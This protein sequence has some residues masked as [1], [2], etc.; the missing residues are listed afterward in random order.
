MSSGSYSST[1]IQSD[2]IAAAGK[3]GYPQFDNMQNLDAINGV[4]R[5]LRFISPDGKRQDT[6]S[7]YLHPRLQDGKHPNLHVL[8]GSPVVRVTFDG[9]RAAGVEYKPKPDLEPTATTEQPIRSVKARKLVIV[10]SGACGTPLVLERSGLGDPDV[11]KQ[12]KIPLVAGIPGVGQ[13]Y[14]DHNLLIY[15]YRSSLRPEET[16]DALAAGRLTP[17]ELFANNDPRLGWNA[18]EVACKIRPSEAEVASIGPEFQ[19]AWNRDF[20][21]NPSKP[22]ALMSLVS[23]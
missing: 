2:F 20:K 23:A 6:A 4:Q 13:G 22:L 18:Q 8:L 7:M 17:E 14:E 1:R 10:S 21:N 5:A 15:S 11:L 12:A 19:E 3:V 16:L 9:T